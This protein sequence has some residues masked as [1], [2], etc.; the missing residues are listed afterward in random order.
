M[1]EQTLLLD[2]WNSPSF[3][4]SVKYKYMS[5][6]WFRKVTAIAGIRRNRLS[7]WHA[8]TEGSSKTKRSRE[9]CYWQDK[10][11]G[12]PLNWAPLLP[13][14][15][16]K[17]LLTS[18]LHS[19]L[20]PLVVTSNFQRPELWEHLWHTHTHTHARP[21]TNENRYSNAEPKG[22]WGGHVHYL[23]IIV[24]KSY[25]TELNCYSLALTLMLLSL[26]KTMT[27]RPA[28]AIEDCY[29]TAAWQCNPIVVKQPSP[30]F[31]SRSLNSWS[32]FEYARLG[33]RIPCHTAAADGGG[34]SAISF[35]L[36]ILP[37]R[38]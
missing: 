6:H 21:N 28:C 26:D 22:V 23:N 35:R 8:G 36:K 7:S 30:I 14:V 20:L 17:T 34:A 25:S 27:T 29:Y 15:S 11:Q 37:K 1:T 10:H 38:C 24:I 4:T 5:L 12:V 13:S 2:R 32:L 33:N 18:R 9:W 19:L 16:K 3:K 31:I